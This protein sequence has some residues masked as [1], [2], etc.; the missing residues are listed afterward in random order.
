MQTIDFNKRGSLVGYSGNFASISKISLTY[1]RNTMDLPCFPSLYFR[2][3]YPMKLVADGVGSIS[4][5]V[6]NISDSVS[7]IAE[8]VGNRFHQ[9]ETPKR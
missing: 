1:A 2:P 5:A 8:G 6:S 9:I 4:D 3:L 7:S